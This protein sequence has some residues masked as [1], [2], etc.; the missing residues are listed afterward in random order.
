MRSTMRCRLLEYAISKCRPRLKGY[1]AQFV[2]RADSTRAQ[3]SYSKKSL[4]PQLG[5]GLRASEIWH[6]RSYKGISSVNTSATRLQP[7]RGGVAARHSQIASMAAILT[8]ICA[9]EKP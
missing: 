1:G 6:R 9:L 2:R 3:D 8:A 7:L 5:Y 4:K